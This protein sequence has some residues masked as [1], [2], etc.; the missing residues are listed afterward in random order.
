MKSRPILFFALLILFSQSVFA[1]TNP[2]STDTNIGIM[3][4]AHGSMGGNQTW[5]TLVK[6]VSAPLSD[7]YPIEV[8][9]GMANAP[10][11]QK[12][13]DKLE[14]QGVNKI[15]VVQLFISSH[16]PIIRQ[17]EY[18]LGLRDELADPAMP[19]M[20]HDHATGRMKVEIPENLQPLDINS[21]ILLTPPLD[22]HPL[23]AE[24]VLDRI[25]TLSTN[26]AKE[27]VL[28]V[29]HGPN[30]PVDNEM[31]LKEIESIGKQIKAELAGRG[32]AYKDIIAHTVRDDADEETHEQA[33]LEFRKYVEDADADGTA[34]V[35]PLLLS[36]GGVEKKYLTRLEGLN[37]K[38]SGETLL[39]HYN[40]SHF[41]QQ[42]V[43][44]ALNPVSQR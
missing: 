33:R 24:I 18:L 6:E 37:F 26:P 7:S 41:I 21:E 8:A 4:L 3:I 1:G 12:A 9:F 20:L 35:I 30:S 10:N 5:N 16:S 42:S 29:A 2:S 23:V 44:E 40:I 32:I 39:P 31:W 17:N 11:M 38:W 25:Q 22:D 13:I 28:I 19:M 27:T 36:K 34:I 43:E 14:A 15:V